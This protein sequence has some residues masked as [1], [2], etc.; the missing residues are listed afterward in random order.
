M[1]AEPKLKGTGLDW[2]RVQRLTAACGPVRLREY[3]ANP[4]TSGQRVERR[5]GEL[6]RAGKTQ[7]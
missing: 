7:P 4:L 1:D 6:R 2:T 3:G 5:N